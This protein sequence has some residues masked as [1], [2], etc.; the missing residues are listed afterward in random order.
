M[1]STL[2]ACISDV[3]VIAADLAVSGMGKYLMGA[4][5]SYLLPQIPN[6]HDLEKKNISWDSKQGFTI[7]NANVYDIGLY[8]CKTTTDSVAHSSR[9]YFVH[10]PG[11]CCRHE[12]VVT[13]VTFPVFN[14]CFFFSSQ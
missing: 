11:Q 13:C 10:R 8:C 2:V 7:R 12:R 6:S 14:A 9:N 5:S 3:Y 1:I 4:V